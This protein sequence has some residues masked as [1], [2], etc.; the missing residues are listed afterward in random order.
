MSWFGVAC[1]LRRDWRNDIEG[2]GA[3]FSNHLPSYYL[4]QGKGWN[5]TRKG[6]LIKRRLTRAFVAVSRE[7][8]NRA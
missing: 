5:K 8:G 3:L 7:R 2:L 6:E 1:E 4:R